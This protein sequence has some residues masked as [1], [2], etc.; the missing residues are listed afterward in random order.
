[1]AIT[2]S[3]WGTDYVSS[4]LRL[5]IGVLAL[6]TGREPHQQTFLGRKKDNDLQ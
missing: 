6:N 2:I 3:L 4:M 5:R 1:M